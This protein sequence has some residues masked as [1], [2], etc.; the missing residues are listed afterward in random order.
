MHITEPGALGKTTNLLKIF[1]SD[2]RKKYVLSHVTSCLVPMGCYSAGGQCRVTC[3]DPESF[4]QKGSNF[5]TFFIG[6]S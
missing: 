6:F 5:F 4:S 1:C 3:A 2:W